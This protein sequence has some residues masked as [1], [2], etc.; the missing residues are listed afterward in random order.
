MVLR[1]ALWVCALVMGACLIAIAQDAPMPPAPAPAPVP[2]PAP[3]PAPT[4]TPAPAP[5]TTPAPSPAPTP[6]PAPPPPSVREQTEDAIR[7]GCERILKM[8]REDGA[9]VL[10][11][12]R[13]GLNGGYY[14]YPVGVSTLGTLALQHALP[15]LN[16]D[17]A[18]R[19][20]DAVNRSI[21]WLT[22]QKLAQKT[23]S[24]ALAICVLY[25]D[26][27][28]K[29]RK[30]I[31]DYAEMLVLSQH[32]TGADA[33]AWG[34]D[35]YLPVRFQNP[36]TKPQ[37]LG[38]ADH[39]NT[40]F[41]VLGLLNADLSDYQVPKRTWQLLEKRYLDFQ[42][43]DGGWGYSPAAKQNESTATMTLASTISLA[44]CEEKLT[45]ADHK[46]CKPPPE[47]RPVENGIAWVA[48]NLDYDKL[49]TYGFYA[50]ERLGILSGRSEF[51]GKPWFEEGQ[52][53]L[54]KDRAW[55]SHGAYGA[56]QQIGA[57]LAVLFLCRGLEPVIINK[58]KRTGDWNDDAYDVKHLVEYVSTYFQKPK[59]WR[60]V[61][62][63]ADVDFLLKTPILYVSGHEKLV[64]TDREKAKIKEYVE[65]GGT[66]FGM[67]CCG[68]KPFDESFRALVAELWPDAPLADLPPTHVIYS[69]PRPLEAKQKLLGLAPDKGSKRLGVIYSP[70]DMCCRW[71]QGGARAKLVFDVGTNI[72]FYVEKN[73]PRPAPEKQ[74]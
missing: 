67:D 43:K 48:K 73:A 16:G 71:H 56:D 64:F 74:P 29:Y 13:F 51:G 63:D 15:H 3:A 4:P 27:P 57:A 1:V 25:Q 70:Y 68:M 72:V 17:L 62:L 22:Q 44:I 47:S 58:L 35:L 39:S 10:D 11:K 33:G 42:N 21:A 40:Q 50:T 53:R 34:Y 36:Q 37:P 61:T 66:L 6:A 60:I 49:E 18:V 26:H 14:V 9:L 55:P 12:E 31:S 28:S 32:Q 30:L 2:E 19:T 20:R 59:Q 23:Y 5:E 38:Q 52:R 8:Q 54:L 65:R 45:A 24:A 46:Q 41:A 69:D 7:E